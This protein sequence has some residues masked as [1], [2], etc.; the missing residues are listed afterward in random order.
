[1]SQKVLYADYDDTASYLIPEGIDLKD[2]KNVC[3][4]VRYNTLYIDTKDGKHFEIEGEI[5]LKSPERCRL[6]VYN[7]E[8]KE[9]YETDVDFN[10][11]FDS[12]SEEESESESE[13]E[14][15]EKPAEPRVTK[16]ESKK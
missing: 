9:E 6:Y 11:S 1:M 5:F 16:I 12:S 3:W 14:E 4:Y 2:T 10:G 15:E 7:K 8:E 13:S